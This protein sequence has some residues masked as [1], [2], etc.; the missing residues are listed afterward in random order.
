MKGDIFHILN[1]GVEKRNIFLNEKD[2]LRFTYNLRDFN[3]KNNVPLSYFH[4]SHSKPYGSPTSVKVEDR[5]IDILCCCLVTNH[6][7]ILAQEKIDKGA[8]KFAQKITGGYTLY[9]NLKN[10]RSGVLFQGGSKIISI[11]RDEH[12]F[13][14]PFYILSNPIKLIE[15]QW[16]E[17]GIKNP[18]KALEFLENYKWSNLPDLIGKDNFPFTTN[19][20]LFYELFDTNEK[21]FRKDFFDWLKAHGRSLRK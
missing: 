12:F 14:L 2:Y 3:N 21:R 10:D 20:D 1:R 5:L 16:K 15:S 19:K 11:K 13:Y 18:R 9:F 8:G 17:K 7:H 6:F 4:R